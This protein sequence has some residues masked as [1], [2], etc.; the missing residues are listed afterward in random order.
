MNSA[1]S[2]TPA[3]CPLCGPAPDSLIW[4]DAQLRV[5]RVDDSPFPGYIRIIW[6]DHATEMTD[7]A[8]EERNHLMRAVYQVETLQRQM[9]QPD[10]INLASL[11]NQ[12]PHLHW[13]LIPRWRSDPC[14]PD[15]IWAPGRHDP[16]Q[17]AAWQRRAQ[18]L[19][20]HVPALCDAIAAAL[21]DA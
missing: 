17:Q 19:S 4:E 3:P 10:K 1:I 5:I 6:R 13:H 11:G 16:A 7:L 14:F 2:P 9:L 21:N 20:S 18:E 8:P 12:V 15:A